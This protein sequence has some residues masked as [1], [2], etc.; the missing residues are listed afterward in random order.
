MLSQTENKKLEHQKN[1]IPRNSKTTSKWVD[2]FV[3]KVG[4]SSQKVLASNWKSVAESL[5]TITEEIPRDAYM[6]TG[7]KN[8][9]GM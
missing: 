6:T 7:V 5:K 2:K 8:N 3:G 1:N 9:T 4:D